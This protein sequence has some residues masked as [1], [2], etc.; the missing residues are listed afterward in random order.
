MRGDEVAFLRNALNFF[1][2]Y[3][4]ERHIPTGC[5]NSALRD[6]IIL[7]YGMR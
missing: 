4:T 5:D 3:S 6:A 7:P 2:A 1:A